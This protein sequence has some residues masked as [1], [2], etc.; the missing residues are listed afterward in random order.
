MLLQQGFLVFVVFLEENFV[1]SV[2]MT[3]ETEVE[4]LGTS[5]VN[6]EVPSGILVVLSPPSIMQLPFFYKTISRRVCRKKLKARIW[7][8]LEKIFSRDVGSITAGFENLTTP[9]AI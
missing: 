1:N 4:S 9:K 8:V 5:F 3:V 7:Y 6:I 2:L